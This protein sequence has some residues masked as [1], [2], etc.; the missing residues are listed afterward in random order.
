MAESGGYCLLASFSTLQK[1]DMMMADVTD[2]TEAAKSLLKVCQSI[3]WRKL[4]KPSTLVPTEDD[5]GMLIFAGFLIASSHLENVLRLFPKLPQALALKAALE[6]IAGNKKSARKYFK[7]LLL[8]NPMDIRC[9]ALLH[10]LQDQLEQ[11]KPNCRKI[12]RTMQ[13]VIKKIEKGLV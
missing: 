12:L 13:P 3:N 6:L 11:S 7:K 8:A 1:D 5:A 9:F 2:A 10:V 4:A